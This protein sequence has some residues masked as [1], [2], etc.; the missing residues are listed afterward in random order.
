MATVPESTDRQ[1]TLASLRRAARRSGG[2]DLCE[3]D[4]RA[5][6]WLYGSTMVEAWVDGDGSVALR[7]WLVLSPERSRALGALRQLAASPVVGR[8][9]LD[10][11]G[12]LSLEHRIPARCSEER[13]AREV[14]ALCREADRLDDLL[15]REVGGSRS[16]DRFQAEVQAALGM[17][18]GNL[19]N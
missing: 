11:E 1:K 13:M 18:G 7:A 12:D 3:L 10:E 15:C 4:R 19:L 6:L 14:D 5:F 9:V 17:S 16:L 8:L 2:D